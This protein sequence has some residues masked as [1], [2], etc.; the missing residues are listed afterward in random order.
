VRSQTI[1]ISEYID[2][3]NFTAYGQGPDWSVAATCSDYT[4]CDYTEARVSGVGTTTATVTTTLGDFYSYVS[5]VP[6][7]AGASWISRAPPDAACTAPASAS[8]PRSA[9]RQA[10]L[11]PVLL[12]LLVASGFVPCM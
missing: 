8:P 10:R 5:T 12:L 2:T 6:I 3:V 7:T 4:S 1:T 11:A 9:A